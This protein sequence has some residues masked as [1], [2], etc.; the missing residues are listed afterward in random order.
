MTAEFAEC[1]LARTMSTMTTTHLT[2]LPADPIERER[3]LD[4]IVS[5][6]EGAELRGGVHV[7][8]LKREDRA[9]RKKKQRALLV[10]RS[11]RLWGIRRRDALLI[12]QG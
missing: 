3:W 5:L 10:R 9:R 7:D 1:S 11:T 12:D 4:A 8:T 6:A 2:H